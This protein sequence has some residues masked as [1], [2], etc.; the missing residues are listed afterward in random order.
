MMPPRTHRR[1]RVPRLLPEQG[2]M[3]ALRL[4]LGPGPVPG[5]GL[6]WHLARRHRQYHRGRCKLQTRLP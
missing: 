1:Q 4:A 6:V 2:R 3:R 5:P